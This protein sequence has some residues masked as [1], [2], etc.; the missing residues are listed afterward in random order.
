MSITRRE[1]M[2]AVFEGRPLDKLPVS[3]RL[4]LWHKDLVSSGCVPK[5]ITGLSQEEV[6][7]YLGF[8][9]AARY[10]KSQPAFRFRSWEERAVTDG[11]VT[12][13][14][15]VFP[16]RVLAKETARS[17]E[18]VRQGIKGHALSYPLKERADYDVMIA[19]MEDAYLDF[20][21]QGF[22]EL[23]EA[24]G[25]AGLP[26][27]ILGSCPA[28]GL[29][30]GW[31]G[32]ENFYYHRADF[33]ETVDLLIEQRE[34]IYRRDLWPA[35]R[36]SPA[37]LILHGVHFNT[38]MTPPPVFE[39]YFLPY[40]REFNQAM[41]EF[42]KKV[43]FHAD[44]EMGGLVRHVME[45]GFDGADCLATAPLVPQRLEDFLEA[46]QGKIVCWG[47]L[48]SILFDPSF[49]MS[50]FGKYV[51]HMIDLVRKRNDFIFGASDNVMPGAEWQ[52]LLF[53]AKA[54]GC[55][56]GG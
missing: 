48:P 41:H 45:A 16:E 19:H 18:M 35:L 12:R 30:L 38:Q 52:R 39:R 9:R 27:L 28:H 22:C 55:A 32:Y 10:R 5:A 13:H 20:D 17:A 34:R 43:L 29:M 7:D 14:E 25:D 51:S 3:V 4:D 8:A 33:G 15:Y 31:A 24:T 53:L 42:G 44:A 26:L 37:Y 46:W 36:D 40:F 23:D 6:E 56:V 47:G 11:D 2:T 1:A 21:L 50:S 54:T 49:P